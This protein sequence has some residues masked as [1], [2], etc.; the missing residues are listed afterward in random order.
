MIVFSFELL[1][2]I[3]SKARREKNALRI[4]KKNESHE[5]CIE[6]DH[7]NS[8]LYGQF[9]SGKLGHMYISLHFRHKRMLYMRE[10][11]Q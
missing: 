7:I 11:K 9:G 1:W 6:V 10:S 3:T 8:Y 5:T 2:R 4:L